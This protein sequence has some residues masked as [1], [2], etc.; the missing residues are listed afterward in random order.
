MKCEAN[1]NA[2]AI[3]KF[4]N[5]STNKYSI[6]KKKYEHVSTLVIRRREHIT[7]CTNIINMHIAYLN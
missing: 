7:K 4:R 1:M 3:V 5:D 2:I 6:L